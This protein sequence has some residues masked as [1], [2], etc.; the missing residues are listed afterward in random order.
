LLFIKANREQTR[1]VAFANQ[2]A[3]LMMNVACVANSYNDGTGINRVRVADDFLRVA[4]PLAADI[5]GRC[6]QRWWRCSAR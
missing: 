6:Q 1:G 2:D 3:A 5:R 4:L